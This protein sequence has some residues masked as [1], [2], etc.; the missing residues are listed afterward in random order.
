M[1]SPNLTRL[2]L[3][4]H[5]EVEESYHKIFGGRIDMNL[6]PRGH[7]QAK[8]LAKFLH[9]KKFGAIYASPM[10][11]VQQ[12]LAPL[13]TNGA[14]P[15]TILKDLREVN[16]GDWTGLNWEQVCEKFNL[17]TTEWL[18]H[19]E[20]GLAPNGESGPQFRARVE[21]CLREIVKNHPGQTTG[22]FCHGGVIRMILSILLELPLPKTN[23]FEIEYASVTQITLH[24]RLAEV[25]LLNF[26]PWRDL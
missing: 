2:L 22:I 12:T 26:T 24:P 10:K 14:P 16:F 3:V 1:S 7:E 25:G 4:R 15:Q 13:L 17:D 6:S 11:R 9:R 5:A 20:R 21:P 19:I 23:S 18:D 8:I